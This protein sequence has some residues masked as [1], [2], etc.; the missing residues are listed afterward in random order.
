MSGVYVSEKMIEVYIHLL[1][2]YR[3][4]LKYNIN[5]T[6]IKIYNKKE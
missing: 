3:N 2:G 6:K 4:N 5:I 1:R